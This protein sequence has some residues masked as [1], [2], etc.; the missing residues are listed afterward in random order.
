MADSSN[1]KPSSLDPELLRILEAAQSG[2]PSPLLDDDP[3]VDSSLFDENASSH[4]ALGNAYKTSMQGGVE[5][6]DDEFTSHGGNKSLIHTDFMIGSAKMD[7]DGIKKDGTRE[8]I[9]R[10]GEWAIDL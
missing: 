4:L 10:Q 9:M 1:P 6:T 3:L 2:M 7:I 5:M 8:P